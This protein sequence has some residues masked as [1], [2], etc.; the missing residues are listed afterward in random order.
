MR[1][2]GAKALYNLACICIVVF[3]LSGRVREFFYIHS[4]FIW[5]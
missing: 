4:P 1:R 2:G 5:G 3:P